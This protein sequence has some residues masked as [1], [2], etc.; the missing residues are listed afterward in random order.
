MPSEGI[1][2][3]P[4]DFYQMLS[5]NLVNRYK[6]S[7]FERIRISMEP[8][9]WIAQ[10]KPRNC[11]LIVGSKQITDTTNKVKYMYQW[12]FSYG[13]LAVEYLNHCLIDSEQKPL[14]GSPGPKAP[15]AFRG[16][17]KG[18]F[19]YVDIKACYFSLYRYVNLDLSYCDSYFDSGSIPFQDTSDLAL[20]KPLRNTLF[21]ILRKAS[22][23]RYK[24]GRYTRTNERS[25][26]YRPMISNYV[27]ST[28]QAV[29]QE[30]WRLF[31]VQQWLTDAAI[32]PSSYAPELIEYLAEEWR[33]D[34]R[35]QARGPAYSFAAGVY[36]I[37]QKV[38]SN[39]LALSFQS[40]NTTTFEPVPISM[41]R[42][43]RREVT[44]GKNHDKSL[45]TIG[46]L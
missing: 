36:K 20:C 23:T 44:D 2:L 7:D 25:Q 9:D 33:L 31:P 38:T 34:A 32:I 18:N 26:Y 24:N 39:L 35:V 13:E 37:G 3:P 8:I 6:A 28:M 5:A 22:R 30:S 27:L 45:H 40:G 14:G 4:T 11:S 15:V 19:A 16:P 43:L 46:P 10:N 12:P 17:T 41:L 21:G 29:A 42:E 1:V